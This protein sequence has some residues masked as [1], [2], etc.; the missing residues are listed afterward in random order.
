MKLAGTIVGIIGVALYILSY[1]FKKRKTI[2]AVYSLANML[3]V[4]QYILLGA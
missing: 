3:Y 4:I 2:V 1:Q